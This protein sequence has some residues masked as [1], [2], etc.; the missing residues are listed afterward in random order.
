MNELEFAGLNTAI[1]DGDMEYQL[2]LSPV[3]ESTILYKIVS[4]VFFTDTFTTVEF[5]CTSSTLD[6][7]DVMFI[8]LVAFVLP[9]VP[10]LPELDDALEPDAAH[11]PL[12]EHVWPEEQA[13]KEPHAPELHIM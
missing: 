12:P 1:D 10:V 3:I 5:P 13:V 7:K 6:G 2:L 8:E 9:V 4:P 11:T